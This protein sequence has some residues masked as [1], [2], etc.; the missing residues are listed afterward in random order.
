MATPTHHAHYRSASEP[1]DVDMLRKSPE[2][3]SRTF[4]GRISADI[5]RSTSPPPWFIAEPHTPVARDFEVFENVRSSIV[6][7]LWYFGWCFRAL[8]C[9]IVLDWDF[10]QSTGLALCY[11]PCPDI[12]CD[13]TVWLISADYFSWESVLCYMII[14]VSVH[15]QEGGKFIPEME[16]GHLA[17]SE[18]KFEGMCTCCYRIPFA[19][20]NISIYALYGM[21]VDRV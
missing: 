3:W 11:V 19:I 8:F 17:V 7:L 1:N 14:I 16:D 21:H 9:P 2:P 4:P 18:V 5:S 13:Y 12:Q 6:I 10:P 15:P 20:I